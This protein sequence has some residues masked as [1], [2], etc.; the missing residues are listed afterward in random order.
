MNHTERDCV[1]S[2][3]AGFAILAVSML[4]IRQAVPLRWYYLASFAAVVAFV[5]VLII[6]SYLIERR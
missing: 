2:L 5:V 3:F 6:A 4:I 1:L